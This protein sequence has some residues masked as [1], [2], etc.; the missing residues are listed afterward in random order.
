MKKKK[1]RFF[2]FVV[3]NYV[4][5][6]R[7][8]K[9][10]RSGFQRHIERKGFSILKIFLN[11]LRLYLFLTRL[12]RYS[13]QIS[14]RYWKRHRDYN[15]KIRHH[16]R[17]NM[18]SEFHGVYIS[19]GG[20]LGFSYYILSES[21]DYYQEE[22]RLRTTRLLL[23]PYQ[24]LA[25]KGRTACR[26]F[27]LLRR[28]VSIFF[29][30]TYVLTPRNDESA[31]LKCSLIHHVDNESNVYFVAMIFRIRLEARRERLHSQFGEF[32]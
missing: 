31:P 22:I 18:F 6:Q 8:N 19:D 29:L 16:N 12:S 10:G 28:Y 2:V 25:A 24:G 4:G 13:Q 21:E 5:F 26:C 17:I 20:V 14:F 7:D 15:I 3:Y 1:Q 30:F 9:N 27:R 23:I 32:N 11:E